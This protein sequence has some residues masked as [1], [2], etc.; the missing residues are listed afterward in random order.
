MHA[1]LCVVTVCVAMV[2]ATTPFNED[3]FNMNIDECRMTDDAGAKYLHIGGNEDFD[4]RQH[5]FT[6][7]VTENEQWSVYFEALGSE[8]R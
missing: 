2:S 3:A 5:R 6:V 4:G 7:N 8:V 1:L